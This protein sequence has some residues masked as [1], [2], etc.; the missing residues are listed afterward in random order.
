MFLLAII[1]ALI[2][3]D[4]TRFVIARLSLSQLIYMSKVG[5]PN[6][7]LWNKNSC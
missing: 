3:L 6:P 1:G 2:E 4:L 7:N 5:L